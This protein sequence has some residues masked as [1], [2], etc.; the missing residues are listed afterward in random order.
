[1]TQ[2]RHLTFD[3]TAYDLLNQSKT[4]APV[5]K[6]TKTGD[7]SQDDV[8]LDALVEG[9]NSF[10]SC[11]M[12][13][14][15]LENSNDSL[16]SSKASGNEN[17]MLESSSSSLD[18]PSSSSSAHG[19]PPPNSRCIPKPKLERDRRSKSVT[20]ELRFSVYGELSSSAPERSKSMDN[21]SD[22]E[23]GVPDPFPDI[24]G[25]P[26]WKFGLGSAMEELFSKHR[27]KDKYP[28]SLD[29]GV[30]LEGVSQVSARVWHCDGSWRS[31][32]I[33]SS[34]SVEDLLL[35]LISTNHSIG[36]KSWSIVE[37]LPDLDLERTLEDH[38]NIFKACKKWRHHTPNRLYFRKDFRKYEVFENPEQFFPSHMVS[39]S[40]D[41]LD[42][43]FET[44]KRPRQP[45]SNLLNPLDSLPEIQGYLHTRE[46]HKR[47][48]KKI[49]CVLRQSGLYFS[50]KGNS[51]DPRHLQLHVQLN[52]VD[53]Y[54]VMNARKK[55]HAPSEFS[56]C[57]K[58]SSSK[59]SMKDIRLFCAEDENTRRCWLTA[60]RLLKYGNT[61]LENYQKALDR[62]IRNKDDCPEVLRPHKDSDD[63]VMMDFSGKQ[64]RVIS[65][66]TEA[67]AIAKEEEYNWRRRGVRSPDHQ[68]ALSHRH[69]IKVSNTSSPV[70]GAAVASNGFHR[71][72]GSPRRN[73]SHSP[74]GSPCNGH[75]PPFLRRCG[76]ESGIHITQPWFHSGLS[77]DET[78]ELFTQQGMVDGMFLI[79]ESQRIPGAFVLSFSQNQ[80]VRH[81]QIVVSFDQGQ[82]LYS[83]DEGNTRFTD[84]VQLVEFYKVN[85]G[86]LPTR[87]LHVCTNL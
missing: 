70:A 52:D 29:S 58:P 10:P 81:Y 7:L 63:R 3:I 36:D 50:L 14:P 54:Q 32:S 25:S 80:K 5:I 78:H 77:R 37:H 24:G 60:F 42:S 59:F 17:C 84:L 46:G 34:H 18:E 39:S 45:L 40:L 23:D 19:S 53:I 67:I 1:M 43:F 49:F 76:I 61:L 16:A 71:G 64:G 86:G 87:L 47:S 6:E 44:P 26:K 30:H 4:M 15:L 57:T 85:A 73:G 55:H 83:L 62:T 69:N 74:R 31:V 11:N 68:L 27:L 79:R 65:N 38:E 13:K 22:E 51:K 82:P 72:A 56:F 75:S 28:G 8:D 9:M 20:D 48:W 2:E 35:R 66:P 12:T 41:R 33:E 21:E